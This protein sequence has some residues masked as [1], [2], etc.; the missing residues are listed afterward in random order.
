MP[1]P[2]LRNTCIAAG[3]ACAALAPAAIAGTPPA[4]AVAPQAASTDAEVPALREPR[5]GLLTAGQPATGAW[6]AL[7]ARGVTTVINLRPETELHGRDEAAEV[8]AAGMAYHQIPV[9][10]SA[11]LTADNAA[12]LW[13]LI[14]SA[15]GRVLVH[16]A[17]GNRV[18]ALLAIGAAS[19]GGMAPEEALAF[20]QSAGLTNPKLT[21]EV[22]K[23]LDLPAQASGD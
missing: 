9:A 7:Q 22:R 23:R 21:A 12:R 19:E 13:Q 3:L 4:Q 16:C 18:G 11:D 1:R 15:E 2:I 14:E 5:E 6:P 17:S 20:G 10:G 8:A